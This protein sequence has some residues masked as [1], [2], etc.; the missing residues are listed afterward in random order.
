MVVQVERNS[1]LK[2]IKI[3]HAHVY[4]LSATKL[5]LYHV[6]WWVFM[7]LFDKKPIL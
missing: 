2:Q 4:T 6:L 5:L 1:G 7:N 3:K